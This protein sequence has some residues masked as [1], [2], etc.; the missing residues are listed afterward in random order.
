M[1]T[2]KSLE[3]I[4]MLRDQSQLPTGSG[5]HGDVDQLDPAELR[6]LTDCVHAFLSDNKQLSAKEKSE[7]LAL[8]ILKQLKSQRIDT[9]EEVSDSTVTLPHDEK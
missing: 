5:Y 8:Q 1:L 9:I 2:Q 6:H 7:R 3:S 4:S